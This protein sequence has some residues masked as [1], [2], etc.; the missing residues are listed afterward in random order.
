MIDTYMFD[1]TT[2][3]AL[4]AMEFFAMADLWDSTAQ[5]PWTA[6]EIYDDFTSA[7]GLDEEQL[8]TGA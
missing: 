1:N 4:Q 7:S 8:R 5:S 6:H 3:L 2:I